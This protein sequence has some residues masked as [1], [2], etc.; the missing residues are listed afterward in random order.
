MPK[1]DPSQLTQHTHRRP[2]ALH[3]TRQLDFN[4]V[5]KWLT[6]EQ[7]LHAASY[8][9]WCLHRH[10]NALRAIDMLLTSCFREVMH[11]LQSH[12]H[13]MSP[14]SVVDDLSTCFQVEALEAVLEQTKRDGKAK[15]ARHRLTVERLR[16]Q[17]VE[18]QV[19]RH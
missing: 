19:M 4:V 17:I 10:D 11:R 5:G 9:L 16:R 13:H 8:A 12:R 15:E 6:S 2:C 14:W 18:L 3:S 7:G 1:Y